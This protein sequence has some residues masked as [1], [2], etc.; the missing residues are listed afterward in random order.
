MRTGI[1]STAVPLGVLSLVGLLSPAGAAKA[2]AVTYDYSSGDVVITNVTVDGVPSI[3][4]SASP[5]FGLAASSSATI[6]TT[7]L[8]LGFALSQ[9]SA[10]FAVPLTGTP[11][12]GFNLNS[13]S[14]ALSGVTLKAPSLLTLS[15]QGSGGYTFSAPSGIAVSGTYDLSGVVTNNGTYNSGQVSFG[16]VDKSFSGAATVLTSADT[17]EIDGLSLG[18]FTI[19][20]QT[21]DVTGNV[22]FD[23]IAPVPVPSAIWLL[24]S[25]LGLIAVRFVRPRRTA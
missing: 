9:S 1:M 20:G 5:E 10:A 24:S 8:T 13:A 18:A 6:D 3:A 16:P 22:I 15:S 7:A 19:K 23:G 2:S 14:F 25:G 17:L 12:G 21:V 4:G 11:T